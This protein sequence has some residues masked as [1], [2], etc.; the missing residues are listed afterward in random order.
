MPVRG[1]FETFS[2]LIAKVNIKYP[3]KYTTAMVDEMRGIFAVAGDN[4]NSDRM[5]D[6]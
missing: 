2:D 6:D 3:Q 5:N 4:G 1:E